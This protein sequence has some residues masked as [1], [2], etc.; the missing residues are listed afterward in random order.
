MRATRLW[1]AAALTIAVACWAGGTALAGPMDIVKPAG[2]LKS[3]GPDAPPGCQHVL[4]KGEPGTGASQHIYR[5]PAGFVFVKHWHVSNENLIMT[6]GTLT[7]AAEGQPD[8]KLAV[9]DYLHIPAKVVHWG[10]CLTECEFYL[11]V[12]GPDSFNVVEKN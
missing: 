11:F 3:C 2:A 5:F 9:G 1:K 12:D 10:V 8:T 7:I 6:K 4:L